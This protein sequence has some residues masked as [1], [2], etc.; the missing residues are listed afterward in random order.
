MTQQVVDHIAVA[1]A[2]GR[3]NHPYKLNELRLDLLREIG[4]EATQHELHDVVM[5]VV[6]D[7]MLGVVVW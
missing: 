5:E 7:V 1:F 6:R 2:T 3:N 4:A